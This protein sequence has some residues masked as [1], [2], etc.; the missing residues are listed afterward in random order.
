MFITSNG[1]RIITILYEDLKEKFGG[2]F[3]LRLIKSF[4]R[5]PFFRDMIHVYRSAIKAIRSLVLN[6]CGGDVGM[7]TSPP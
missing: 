6:G 5:T 2:Q 7:A 4:T 1:I 3:Q